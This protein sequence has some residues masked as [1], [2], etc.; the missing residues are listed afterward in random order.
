[1][2]PGASVPRL[3]ASVP[4][5]G[6]SVPRPGATVPQPCR[7]V[8]PGCK[9]VL[10]PRRSVLRPGTP[11]L[12][13]ATGLFFGPADGWVPSSLCPLCLCG[14]FKFAP[15]R[16]RCSPPCKAELCTPHTASLRLL[17]SA[18]SRLC[19]FSSLR[20]LVSA[21]SRLCVS[22]PPARSLT[23]AALWHRFPTGE[24]G[25]KTRPVRLPRL[26]AYL[27]AEKEQRTLHGAAA[28]D[29]ETAAS[30]AERGQGRASATLARADSRRRAVAALG[31]RRP[32]PPQWRP[33]PPRPPLGDSPDSR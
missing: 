22:L 29:A 9:T 18:S 23:V 32:H 5:P 20:L 33:H 16:R 17:V 11:V 4:R 25:K 6:A 27:R 3:G 12:R 19:V 21:S 26:H 28:N 31:C 2:R 15:A 7:S 14:S 10:Q 13:P 30:Q 1:M 24:C 8:L